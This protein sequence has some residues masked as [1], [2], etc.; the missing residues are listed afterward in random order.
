[1]IL[2]LTTRWY[3]CTLP[4]LVLAQQPN[5]AERHQLLDAQRHPQGSNHKIM[6]LGVWSL[7]FCSK[8]WTEDLIRCPR[9][10]LVA[11]T[12]VSLIHL[13]YTLQWRFVPNDSKVSSA[14]HVIGKD[15]VNFYLKAARRMHLPKEKPNVE[16]PG[17][18]WGASSKHIRISPDGRS[19]FIRD[20]EGHWE[21]APSWHPC[22][23]SPGSSWNKFFRNIN[24]PH[25]NTSGNSQRYPL[26]YNVPHSAAVLSETWMDYYQ[27]L[28]GRF[29]QV[30]LYYSSDFVR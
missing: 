3:L 1:M 5:R 9:Q 19:L 30:G 13:A 6:S 12:A 16:A 7:L 17:S 15:A 18:N 24:A 14:V 26:C 25:F 23:A 21:T 28:E 22:R 11:E 2:N 10:T 27:E 29:D 8:S 20:N 4:T